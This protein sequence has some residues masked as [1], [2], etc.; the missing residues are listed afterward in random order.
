MKL[1]KWPGISTSQTQ[2]EANRTR[3][4]EYGIREVQRWSEARQA[5]AEQGEETT[6]RFQREMAEHARKWGTEGEGMKFIRRNMESW[7][8]ETERHLQEADQ[9]LA[10]YRNIVLMQG[11]I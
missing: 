2:E 6:R 4:Y 11:R 1:L 3:R 9:R 5:M 8:E 10:I 7:Q